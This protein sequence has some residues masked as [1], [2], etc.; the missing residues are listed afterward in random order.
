MVNN[1]TDRIEP[2]YVLM[3]LSTGSKVRTERFGEEE[4]REKL[5][6][7]MLFSFIVSHNNV[8]E[9]IVC[10]RKAKRQSYQLNVNK[11]NMTPMR[12]LLQQF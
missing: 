1:A 6:R 11:N 10:N 4:D 12:I 3:E 8:M 7:K 5:R 2:I 9:Y